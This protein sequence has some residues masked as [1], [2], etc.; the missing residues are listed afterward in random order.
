MSAILQKQGNHH[1]TPFWRS[2]MKKAHLKT[3]YWFLKTPSYNERRW[4]KN[5][6]R[7][8]VAILNKRHSWCCGTP[9]PRIFIARCR[10]WRKHI[11][12]IYRC[13]RSIKYFNLLPWS[14]IASG[15][16]N[17]RAKFGC[18]ALNTF[19]DIGLRIWKWFC[20]I[21]A[22]GVSNIDQIWRGCIRRWVQSTVQIWCIYV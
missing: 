3:L 18:R 22:N 21:Q 17:Q 6:F 7:F 12:I 19:R 8:T 2:P 14:V 5:Y 15:G 11:I 13:S 1:R 9:E 10:N 20:V 16:R 4:S